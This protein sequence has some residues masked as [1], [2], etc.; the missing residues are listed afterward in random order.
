MSRKKCEKIE[1]G[2]SNQRHKRKS[3]RE[4]LNYYIFMGRGKRG[5]Q[6]TK[7]RRPKRKQLRKKERKINIKSYRMFPKH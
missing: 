1:K 2:K 4:G 6:N 7:R 3:E 5:A